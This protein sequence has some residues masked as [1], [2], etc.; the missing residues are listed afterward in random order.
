MHIAYAVHGSGPVL[1]RPGTYLTHLEYDWESPVWRHWLDELG[2]VSTVVRY[3]DRGCGLSDRDV[4]D[5]SLDAWVGDLEAVL[6][7]CG[8]ET[9]DLFGISQGCAVAVEY[10]ARHPE[11]VRRMMLYGGY[12]RGRLHRSPP[13][14]R[15]AEKMISI[16]QLA[17]GSENPDFR[18]AFAQLLVPDATAAELEPI[19]DLQRRSAST[20]TAAAIR[21]ARNAIDVSAS[22]RQV[23]TPTLVAHAREDVMVPFA[24]GA[25]LASLIPDAE[26]LPLAGRNHLMRADDEGFPALVAHMN[27]FLGRPVAAPR[28]A[29]VELT[30]RE[31]EIIR[32]VAAGLDNHA[33]AAELVLSPVPSSVTCRTCTPSSA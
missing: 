23:Q 4:D 1:V 16:V 33:I 30:H 5:F 12:A 9:F 6:E 19:I 29:D 17:W 20:R 15:E 31:R 27:A 7:A 25:H 28:P 26:F 13:E 3:D 14:Q 8:A 32:L 18:R 11:R 2:R 21:G 24:E 10:A 22:A